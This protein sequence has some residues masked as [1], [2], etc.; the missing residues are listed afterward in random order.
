MSQHDEDPGLLIKAKM[1]II[2]TEYNRTMAANHCPGDTAR[3]PDS[4]SKQRCIKL[5]KR[6]CSISAT[7]Y[8]NT[9]N[10]IYAMNAS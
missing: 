2:L 10:T 5:F 4:G 9:K 1:S 8:I 3:L 6:L 7:M